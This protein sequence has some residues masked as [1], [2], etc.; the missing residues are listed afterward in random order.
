MRSVKTAAADAGIRRRLSFVRRR[1][2]DRRGLGIL[3]GFLCGA[4]GPLFLNGFLGLRRFFGRGLGRYLLKLYRYA[5]GCRRLA[6]AG[7]PRGDGIGRV[8]PGLAVG[9]EFV[10]ARSAGPRRNIRRHAAGPTRPIIGNISGESA[11]RSEHR[12]ESEQDC[13][14]DVPLDDHLRHWIVEYAASLRRAALTIVFDRAHSFDHFHGLD[15]Q[16]L[17]RATAV[18]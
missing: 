17:D 5:A 15:I 16:G 12:T 2:R 7:R 1:R 18:Q 4:G 11:T 14:R 6:G 3:N 9:D 13:Y 8:W 10:I